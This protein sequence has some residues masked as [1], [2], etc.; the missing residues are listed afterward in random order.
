RCSRA[1]PS[2]NLH[3]AAPPIIIGLV[4]ASTFSRGGISVRRASLVLALLAAFI[5]ASSALTNAPAAEDTGPSSPRTVKLFDD[6]W[7]FFKGDAEGAQDVSFDDSAWRK[8]D[9]P[10]DWS[11]E[12]PFDQNAPTGGAGGYLPGGIG[13]YRKHFS[14]PADCKAKRVC[15]EFDGVMANSEVWIN[16][17]S[18]GKRPYGYV[19]FRYDMTD[20]LNLGDGQEN[21]LAVRCGNSKQPA[22]RWY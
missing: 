8:L 13:W 11:I 1:G 15:I 20:H 7:L 5:L 14:L 6:D 19:S 22:S 10:H 12:G 9:V 3:A 21:I 4:A 17:C 18:L 16:G 2:A